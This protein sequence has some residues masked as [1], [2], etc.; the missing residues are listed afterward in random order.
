MSEIFCIIRNFGFNPRYYEKLAKKF[1]ESHTYSI[2]TNGY[3]NELLLLAYRHNMLDFMKYLI[4]KN[5][6]IN[7]RYSE[8]YT[9]LMFA[10]Q[11]S[12]I[13]DI[14]YIDLLINNNVDANLKCIH[15]ETALIKLINSCTI[16]DKYHATF[17]DLVSITDVSI[18]D[19][20]GKKAIDHFCERSL[21]DS[22]FEDNFYLTDY[23]F[24]L[25]QYGINSKKDIKSA[26]NV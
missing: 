24:D 15:G 4:G 26:S 18:I 9:I 19:D 23:E 22:D 10:C 20:C 3:H 13:T 7:T 5:M 14:P 6:N 17:M 21:D 16:Y 1:I 12:H 8:G 2:T 25:L 11:R